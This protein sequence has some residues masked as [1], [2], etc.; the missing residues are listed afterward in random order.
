MH[1]MDG[2]GKHAAASFGYGRRRKFM[3]GADANGGYCLFLFLRFVGLGCCSGA[4][5]HQWC[6]DVVQRWG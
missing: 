4:E 6:V 5:R 3:A 2:R 1:L